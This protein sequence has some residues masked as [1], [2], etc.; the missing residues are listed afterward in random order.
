[1]SQFKSATTDFA[2]LKRR[3]EDLFSEPWPGAERDAQN[4]ADIRQRE[5][6]QP[7]DPDYYPGC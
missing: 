6:P 3:R 2:E 1:M 7:D 5:E 4:G